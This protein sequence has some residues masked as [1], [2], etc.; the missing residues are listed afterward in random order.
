MAVAATIVVFVA[1]ALGVAVSQMWD[2][3]A[4]TSPGPAPQADVVRSAPHP[5]APHDSHAHE[6]SDIHD[7]HAG[8]DHES[9]AP[10]DS[11]DPHHGHNHSE[12]IYRHDLIDLAA[13]EVPESAWTLTGAAIRWRDV[14][15]GEGD[16]IRPGQAPYLFVTACTPDGR[17]VADTLM[18][19][20]PIFYVYEGGRLPAAF[21]E[22]IKGMKTGGRRLL[23]WPGSNRFES[24]ALIIPDDIYPTGQDL[25]FSVSFFRQVPPE[26]AEAT[27]FQ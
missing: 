22:A 15:V 1:A 23:L 17:V 18:E 3:N 20:H 24:E 9:D 14:V 25:V 5:A 16:E 7:D 27:R 8:H 6:V 13:E 2:R 19:R 21:D 4:R 10:A 11:A 12:P 26:P